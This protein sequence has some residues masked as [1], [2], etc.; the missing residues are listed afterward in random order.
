[1]IWVIIKNV[2]SYTMHIALAV[3]TKME[4]IIASYA[5]AVYGKT[6]AGGNFRGFTVNKINNMT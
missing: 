5:H 3:S 6:P 4:L 2:R 1:M